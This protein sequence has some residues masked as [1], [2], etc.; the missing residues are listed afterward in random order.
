M[1]N[2][3]VHEHRLF[4]QH[5]INSGTSGSPK[6]RQVELLNR[7]TIEYTCQNKISADKHHMTTLWTQV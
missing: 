2:P 5:C 6:D 4:A 3:S 7:I 1:L